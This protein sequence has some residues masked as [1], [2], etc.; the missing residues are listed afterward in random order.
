MHTETPFEG[1]FRS[2]SDADSSASSLD[3]FEE[4]HANAPFPVAIEEDE[5][6][7]QVLHIPHTSPFFNT[8]NTTSGGLDYSSPS[9]CPTLSGKFD[10]VHSAH[11]I[12]SSATF[13]GQIK[14]VIDFKRDQMVLSG[15]LSRRWA[16]INK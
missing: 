8:P 12:P 5:D 2:D 10:L 6:A 9:V 11:N 4:G 13:V 7:S 14:P 15:L 16:R 3:Q 1:E